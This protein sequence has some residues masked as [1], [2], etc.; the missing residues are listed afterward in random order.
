M[1]LIESFRDDVYIPNENKRKKEVSD[2][3]AE[4]PNDL[5]N[6]LRNMFN[7]N[8]AYITDMKLELDRS[9]VR[10]VGSELAGGS[11]R[12]IEGER[13]LIYRLDWWIH[14]FSVEPNNPRLS[15]ELWR[16]FHRFRAIGSF[17][18]S[19]MLRE[20]GEYNEF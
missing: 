3:V 6:Y 2:Y 13:D 16:L 15:D 20:I 1:D 18:I 8:W 10:S 5:K 14:L 17:K 9:I 7:W 4:L 11:R 19:D 12:L